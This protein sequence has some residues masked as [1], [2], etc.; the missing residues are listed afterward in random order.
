MNRESIECIRQKKSIINFF[1]SGKG[2]YYPVK[3]VPE[4]VLA[5]DEGFIRGLYRKYGLS[6]QEPV[7]YAKWSGR[8]DGIQGQDVILAVK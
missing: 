7:Y 2:Y 1:Y 3:D 4:Q 5:Y 6:I 8:D